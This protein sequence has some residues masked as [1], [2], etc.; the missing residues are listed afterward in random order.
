LRANKSHNTSHTKAVLSRG[1]CVMPLYIS[2]DTE[3][4]GSWT[5]LNWRV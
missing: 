1:D 5:W 3:S 2:I 4:A